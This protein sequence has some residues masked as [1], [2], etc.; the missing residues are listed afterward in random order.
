MHRQVKLT[1]EYLIQME[2]LEI[3]A[4]QS[5]LDLLIKSNRL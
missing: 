3:I 4:F 2:Y 1:P 5:I